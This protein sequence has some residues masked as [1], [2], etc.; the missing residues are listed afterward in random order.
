MGDPEAGLETI[1]LEHQPGEQGA[2]QA[3]QGI[4]HVVE[5]H[6][7]RYPICTG[8][9]DDE[10]AV[11]GGAMANRAPNTIKPPTRLMAGCTL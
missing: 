2:Q 1:E 6:I 4:G 5:A 9:A 3:P 11:Q 10:V 7:E 8:I